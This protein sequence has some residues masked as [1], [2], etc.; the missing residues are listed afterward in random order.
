VL[1]HH[2]EQLEAATLALVRDHLRLL[3]EF[4]RGGTAGEGAARI[5]D[6]LRRRRPAPWFVPFSCVQLFDL[7]HPFALI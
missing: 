6:R 2:L 5:A 7:V 1:S 4:D 3:L